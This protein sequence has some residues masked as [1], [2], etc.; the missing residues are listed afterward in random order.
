MLP[1]STVSPYSQLS[2]VHQAAS[3]PRTAC[4][5]Q[6]SHLLLPGVSFSDALRMKRSKGNRADDFQ[7]PGR[8]SQPHS[9]GLGMSRDEL[10]FRVLYLHLL[11]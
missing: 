2:L 7:F 5:S 11:K 3:C 9:L 1:Q 6:A 10:A 4:S 8:G